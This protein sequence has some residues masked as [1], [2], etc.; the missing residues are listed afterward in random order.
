MAQPPVFLSHPSSLEHDTGPHP[1]RAERIVA[2][3]R[4]LDDR[5]WMGLE[6]VQS[7]RA[8]RAELT[9]I[10]PERHVAMIEAAAER[11]G[12]Q[13]DLDTV[14]SAGSFVAALHGAG[15]A[16]TLV[17]R[18]LEGTAPS[19]F[20]VHRP[21]GHHATREQAMGFCLFNN[22]AIAAQHALDSHGLE[23]VMIL[24][25]DVHHGNGTNDIFHASDRVLF[26][27]IHQ[28]PLYPGTGAAQDDG[29][30]PGKGYTVNLPVPPGSGDA[31]YLSLVDHVVAPLA[32]AFSPQLVLISAGY[33]AHA[34]DPLASC[35]VSDDGFAGMTR[36]TRAVAESLGIPLG[37]VLEGGYALGA[38]A[39]SVAAT[40]EQL[41]APSPS[42]VS[43]NGV[44]VASVAEQ[45]RERLVAHW[46][47][48]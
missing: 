46:P 36:S 43:G 48:L 35:L 15:G 13:I 4:E 47:G 1:E 23:R 17:D 33:D 42:Q 5:G 29:S 24:D 11:G 7:P 16:V 34:E 28:W 2:I 32:H 25:W 38:L 27:S 26:V 19:G 40:L 8:T 37:I 14:V 12:A 3:E 9:A 6:R 20:S 44:A 41:V 21:P 31:V 10:H 39:R 22:I 18:L 45:A 30:G